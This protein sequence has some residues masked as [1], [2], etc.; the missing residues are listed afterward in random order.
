M[1]RRV[2]RGMV[3]GAVGG[4]VVACLAWARRE[5]LRASSE[6]R[7]RWEA[8]DEGREPQPPPSTRERRGELTRWRVPGG[9]LYHVSGL[10]GLAFVPDGGPR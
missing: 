6:M 4:A 5:E 3:G 9:W 1:W 10:D 2:L 7:A 8:E